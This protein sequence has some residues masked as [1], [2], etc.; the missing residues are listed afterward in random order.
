MRFGSIGCVLLSVLAAGAPLPDRAACAQGRETAVYAVSGAYAYRTYCASCHGTDGK[1]EG[2][3]AQNLRFHP[4]DLTELAKKNGGEY[5]ADKVNR[6]I[7]GRS[8][9]KGHG[10]P[11]MPIWGDAFKNADTGYDEQTVKDKIRSIVDYLR[12][13]QAK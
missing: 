2:P 5:P 1:G 3:L 4:P 6:I 10:G 13:L 11:E 8:P 7:D 12:T 9:L